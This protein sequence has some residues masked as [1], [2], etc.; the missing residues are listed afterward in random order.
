MHCVRQNSIKEIGVKKQIILLG[1]MGL[2][3][4][5][6]GCGASVSESKDDGVKGGE[7]V[8][9]FPA[10][11][12]KRSLIE[13]G[14]LEADSNE[15]VF[16]YRGYVIEYDTTNEKGE[17]VKA[18]GLIVVPTSEGVDSTAKEKLEYMKSKGFSIVSDDHGTIFA[19]EN[20]PSVK[21]A[22]QN[23]PQGSP[24][25]LTSLFGFVTLQPDYIG[26][27]SSANEY[28]PYLLKRSL[29]SATADFIKAAKKFAKANHIPLNNQVYLTGY[30]EGGYA[31]LATLE[32]ME[33]DSNSV[34]YAAPMAGPYM[35]DKMAQS[36][37]AKDTI[38]HPS[39]IADVAYAYSLTYNKPLSE[40][41]KSP[42]DGM[43]DTLFSGDMSI[44]EIDA[45]LPKRVSGEDGLFQ[46]EVV[47]RVLA[48]DSNY[49]FYDALQQNSTAYWAPKTPTKFIHCLGDD[50][51]PYSM[52]EGT[53]NIMQN[54]Y[55]A[56]NVDILPVEVAIT[57]NPDSEL[58]LSHSE[59]ALPAYYV[60]GK[61]FANVR[62]ETI[63]Y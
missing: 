8:V 41:V 22:M 10:N 19:N 5:I 59:C 58:R 31:A 18:S 27:G 40:L 38:T 51:V 54:I 7:L 52:S 2:A 62:K 17:R 47:D 55:G 46:D 14:I 48:E 63:G 42:Y 37:L 44:D 20:A 61:L 53:V 15:S 60:V 49:W 6:S 11:L 43:L 29:A 24:I 39:F 16:G 4:F 45:A 25:M 1:V 28:H 57:N 13:K 56:T 35:M 23:I 26:F 32:K 9:D 12:L 33:Q 3:L 30:S 50:V 21:A 34:T 36:I